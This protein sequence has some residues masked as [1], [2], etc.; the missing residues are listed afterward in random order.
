MHWF[1]EPVPANDH[2]R[3]RDLR[4]P[5]VFNA[6]VAKEVDASAS[7]QSGVPQSLAGIA[8]GEKNRCIRIGVQS[9]PIAPGPRRAFRASR[10][11]FR[12]NFGES[13]VPVNQTLS[14][15]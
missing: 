8:V 9:A 4:S 11:N 12:D 6:R 2:P 5:R 13:S 1:R 14:Y 3:A 15:T 7:E 10:D